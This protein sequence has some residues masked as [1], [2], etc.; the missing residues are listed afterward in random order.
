MNNNTK[1]RPMIDGREIIQ[2]VSS[3]PQPALNAEGRCIYCKAQ[4]GLLEDPQAHYS[5]CVWAESR[6]RR[7]E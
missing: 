4:G 6:G 1:E 2:T 7:P 5:D 3:L